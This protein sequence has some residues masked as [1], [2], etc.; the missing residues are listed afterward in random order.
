MG[1][2]PSEIKSTN[3]RNGSMKHGETS[4][5]LTDI[6]YFFPAQLRQI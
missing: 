2:D 6:I 3:A 5:L 1:D 4:N